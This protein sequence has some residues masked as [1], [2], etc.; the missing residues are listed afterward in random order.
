ML[1]FLK[2]E[3]FRESSPVVCLGLAFCLT[4]GIKGSPIPDYEKDIPQLE[5]SAVSAATAGDGS[6]SAG[7]SR[8]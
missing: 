5:S 8:R 4:G 2:M 1:S 3:F 6:S 7:N